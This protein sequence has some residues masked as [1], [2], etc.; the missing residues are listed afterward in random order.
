MRWGFAEVSENV[1]YFWWLHVAVFL[2]VFLYI[3]FSSLG[4]FFSFMGIKNLQWNCRSLMNK[5]INCS[6]FSTVDVLVIQK[7][8]L[9]RRSLF[10]YLRKFYIVQIDLVAQV[11]G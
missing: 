10:L 3:C 9:L 4:V 2:I 8:F 5:G 11:M 6:P 7:T 1:C